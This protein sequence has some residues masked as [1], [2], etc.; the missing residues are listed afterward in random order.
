[1]RPL[2]SLWIVRMTA[3]AACHDFYV[4]VL[5]PPLFLMPKATLKHSFRCATLLLYD[6]RGNKP[7]IRPS[8]NQR[9]G[10]TRTELFSIY[11]SHWS[12]LEEN[13][14]IEKKLFL[15][16]TPVQ[17]RGFVL[18]SKRPTLRTST[19]RPAPFPSH[20]VSFNLKVKWRYMVYIVRSNPPPQGLLMVKYI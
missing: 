18:W 19:T 17:L 1:M 4:H 2:S 7:V 6:P 11:L 16:F 12:I 8:D 10:R 3:S 9:S 20:S 13:N 5:S 14:V 15:G